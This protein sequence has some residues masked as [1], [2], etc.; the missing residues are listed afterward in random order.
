MLYSVEQIAETLGISKVTVYRKLKLHE[1][2]QFTV[3]KN[4][5]TF[6]E[7][8]GL[9]IIRQ[10]LSV[11]TGENIETNKNCSEAEIAIDTEQ[12]Q[13]V[14]DKLIDTLQSDIEYLRSQLSDREHF[15]RSQLQEK[16]VQINSKDRQIENMQTLM[17]NEQQL[18]LKSKL[19][20]EARVKEVDSMLSIVR[21]RMEER[22]KESKGFFERFFSKNS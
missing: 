22:K 16:D 13:G 1:V 7:E 19:L 3:V 15:Y 12:L 2:K 9:D 6:L 8:T 5:K 18:H 11:T 21:E 10:S 14:K 17:Q 4:G 20:E